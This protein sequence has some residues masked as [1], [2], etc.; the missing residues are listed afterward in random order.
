M[1]VVNLCIMTVT[2]LTSAVFVCLWYLYQ[3]K[4]QGTVYLQHAKGPATIKTEHQTG[5]AHIESDSIYA[6]VYA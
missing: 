3:P 1:R 2:L 6:T 4:L 5:I